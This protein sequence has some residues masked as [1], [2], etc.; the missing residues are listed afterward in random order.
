MTLTIT[1]E[2]LPLQLNPDGVVRVGGTRVTLDTVVAAFNQGAT[3]EEIVFQYPSLQLADVY[4]VIAYY[5]RHQQEVEEY[6][7][8]RQKRANEIRKINEARCDPQGLRQRLMA[9]R[10]QFQ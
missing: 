1:T 7:Q 3:A 5:L 10:T 4:A 8:Q 6:L 9:R 2:P